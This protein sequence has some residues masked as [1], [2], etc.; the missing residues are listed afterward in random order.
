MEKNDLIEETLRYI[1]LNKGKFLGSL[2]GLFFGILFLIIG[3]LKTLLL[4]ICVFIGYF[5]GTGLDTE[6]SIKKFLDRIL[7]PVLR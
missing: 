1:I 4:F 2:I 7:P 3:F 5:I 6:G